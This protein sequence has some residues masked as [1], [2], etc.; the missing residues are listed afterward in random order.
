MTIID[1]DVPI[2]KRGC[3]PRGYDPEM[4]ITDQP[5]L[6][7]MDTPQNVARFYNGYSRL[8]FERL[9]GRS[10]IGVDARRVEW[11][12]ETGEQGEVIAHT[13]E[14]GQRWTLLWGLFSWWAVSYCES[15]NLDVLQVVSRA[16]LRTGHRPARPVL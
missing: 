13:V 15:P 16:F 11:S 6:E 12:H 14:L 8:E 1:D 5:E 4:A 9:G 7:G 10:L 3:T 2:P